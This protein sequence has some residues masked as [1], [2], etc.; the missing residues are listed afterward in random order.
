[1]H[2]RADGSEDQR[3]IM[4]TIGGARSQ[5]ELSR[6]PRPGMLGMHIEAG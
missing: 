3:R 6:M 4:R 2:N 1:M 5:R